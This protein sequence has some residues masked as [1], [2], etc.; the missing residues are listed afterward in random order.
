MTVDDYFNTPET[1]KPMELVYGVMRASDSPGPRHQSA[2][3][4]F[5]LALDTDRVRG[6]P[7][8]VVEVLSPNPRIGTTAER[9]EWSR[10]RRAAPAG[11]ARPDVVRRPAGL[12]VDAQGDPRRELNVKVTP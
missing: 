8:L 2:V 5:F 1:L 3:G 4:Q 9:V 7:D 6:A 12:F 10:D 11:R